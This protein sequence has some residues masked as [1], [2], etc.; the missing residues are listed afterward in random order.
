MVKS[1]FAMKR[2]R[3]KQYAVRSSSTGE[4]KFTKTRRAQATRRS[5][6][7]VS[8]FWDDEAKVWVAE[9]DDVPGLVTEAETI[10]S[11]MAKL[12]VLVPELLQENRVGRA[13]RDLPFELTVRDRNERA[14]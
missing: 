1:G 2:G 9:S 6:L 5:C 12:R 7:K 3:G 13:M 11:L 8:A 10:D 4:F 14:A